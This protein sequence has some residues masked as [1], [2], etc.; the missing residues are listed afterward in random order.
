MR[1]AVSSPKLTNTRS[2]THVVASP[3]LRRDSEQWV[4][5]GL[6]EVGCGGDAVADAGGFLESAAETVHVLVVGHRVVLLG[7]VLLCVEVVGKCC[8]ALFLEL[9][10]GDV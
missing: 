8:V 9:E 2:Q 5:A 3:S 4:S 10:P 6:H 7:D 1:Q